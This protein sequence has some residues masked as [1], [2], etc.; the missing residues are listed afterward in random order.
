MVLQLEDMKAT[1]GERVEDGSIVPDKPLAQVLA[2]AKQAKEDA[3]QALWKSMKT[4]ALPCRR[5]LLV[6]I[7]EIT[8]SLLVHVLEIKELL[9]VYIL[10]SMKLLLVYI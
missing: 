5:I 6:Y 2:D 8:E 10:E 3:F 9:L 7:L 1:R 4:G